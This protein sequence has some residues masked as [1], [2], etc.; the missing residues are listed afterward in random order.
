MPGFRM[1]REAGRRKLAMGSKDRSNKKGRKS[2]IRKP[3]SWKPKNFRD[4]VQ[5]TERSVSVRTG[6]DHLSKSS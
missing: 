6:D 1:H 3:H 4:K 2:G 5:V